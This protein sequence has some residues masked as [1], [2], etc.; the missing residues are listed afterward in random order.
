[1][2]FAIVAEQFNTRKRRQNAPRKAHAKHLD[3][4]RVESRLRQQM[5]CGCKVKKED[6]N[7]VISPFH[8]LDKDGDG[9][10]SI[11]EVR[12][13]ITQELELPLS[14]TEINSVIDELDVSGDGLVSIEEFEDFLKAEIRCYR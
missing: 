11:G 10:L 12:K 14:Q 3:K 7:G 1:M 6:V 5:M 2:S 9:E 4:F 13:F 8:H